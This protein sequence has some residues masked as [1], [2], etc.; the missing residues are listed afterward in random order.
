M[1]RPSVVPQLGLALAVVSAGVFLVSGYFMAQ[2][3][4][5]YYRAEP[6]PQFLLTQTRERSFTAFARPVKIDDD[7][8]PDGRRALR[9]R[10]GDAEL[11][12][13]VHAGAPN[14]PHLGAYD[15]WLAVLAFQPMV[16]GQVKVDVA[17]PASAGRLVLIK[18][19]AAPGFEEDDPAGLV[20]RKLWTFDLIEFKSDGTLSQRLLQFRDRRGRLPALDAD[21]KSP[22]ESIQE[23]SWEWQAALFAI[24]KLYIS[25]YR[26][27][28]DAVNGN[29]ENEGMGWTLPAA[30]VSVLAGTA[31]IA[32]FLSGFVRRR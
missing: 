32:L 30:G 20:G 29:P 2:R 22:V 14:V 18:R 12:L 31:G 28:T 8:T 19:N 24:P 16:A 23:R 13:P 3:V 26:Y 11:L 21:P 17:D 6:P 27:R 4:Q 1:P 25:S 7:T 10:F 9:I 5:A 15:E